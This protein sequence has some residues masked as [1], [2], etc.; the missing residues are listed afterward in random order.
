MSGYGLL[1]LRPYTAEAGAKGRK[2]MPLGRRTLV[3]DVVDYIME[4]ILFSEQ[5]RQGDR[6]NETEIARELGLSKAPVR[7]AMRIL[8]Q[9][10]VV[11]LVPNKGVFVRVISSK[12]LTEIAEV[13]LALEAI[14]FRE[15]VDKKLFQEKDYEYLRKIVDKMTEIT[16]MSASK[17]EKVRL[18]MEQD[19]KFHGYYYNDMTDL[20]WVK[21]ILSD[22]YA[23]NAL[24][25]YERLKSRDLGGVVDKHRKLLEAFREGDLQKM[26]QANELT[27]KY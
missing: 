15:I 19:V 12:E 25:R 26:Y 11:R 10:G 18:F 2:I 21:K 5:H 7:E 20:Q 23:I 13:R 27:I 14:I 3:E 8:A 9:Q 6:L 22:I 1:T 24:G 4:K 17:I 16:R